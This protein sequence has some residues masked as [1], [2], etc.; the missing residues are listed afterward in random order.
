MD[1]HLDLFQDFKKQ[2]AVFQGV[3]TVTNQHLLQLNILGRYVI[4]TGLNVVT[5]QRRFLE[6]HLY[7]RIYDT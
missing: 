4:T 5:S 7:R 3:T 1:L 6:M 2:K